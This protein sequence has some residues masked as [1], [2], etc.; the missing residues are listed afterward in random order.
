MWTENGRSFPF[1][2][3][4]IDMGMKGAADEDIAIYTNADICLHTKASLLIATAMQETNAL[5]AYRRDF[6]FETKFPLTDEQ[7]TSGA[8]YPG[9]DLYAFRYNWWRRNSQNFPD[10]IL[11]AEAWD[12]CLRVLIEQTNRGRLTQIDNIIYHT[13]HNSYWEKPENR[14]K[15]GMQRHCLRLAGAF[16]ARCGENP[17]KYGIPTLDKIPK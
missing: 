10:L 16:L 17:G 2:K 8:H 5:F 13:R 15:L 4:V 12:A 7:I 11:G 1:V 3:D 6:G 9:S 14:Y